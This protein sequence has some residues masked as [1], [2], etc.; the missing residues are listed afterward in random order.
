MKAQASTAGTL[1]VRTA[2]P[3]IV[4]KS[5]WRAVLRNWE[6]YLF[7]IPALAYIAIFMYAPMY[8]VLMAFQDYNMAAGISAALGSEWKIFSGSFLVTIFGLPCGTHWPLVYIIWRPRCRC[9]WC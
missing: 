3:V 6:L 5:K 4:R 2:A 1:A 8:G 7:L 9:R